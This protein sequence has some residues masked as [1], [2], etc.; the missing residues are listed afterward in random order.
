MTTPVSNL[1]SLAGKK[2]VPC[3]GGNLPAMTEQ[4]A[5]AMLKHVNQDWVLGPEAKSIFREFSFKG[6][7]KTMGFV[8][9]VAWIVNQEGHHPELEISY[10]RCKVIFKTHAL[11]GLSENDFICA[12]KIDRLVL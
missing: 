10:D 3:E 2:C 11:D 6:F 8:N 4:E 7:N 5:Q 12:Q 9:A 1:N